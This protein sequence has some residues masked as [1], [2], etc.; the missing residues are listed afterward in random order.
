MTTSDPTAMHQPSLNVSHSG[1]L[2]S[3]PETVRVSLPCTGAKEEA[4]L[5]TIGI[6]VKVE[7]EKEDRELRIK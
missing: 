1:T 3:A 6:S 2:P 4:V 5:V 7:G